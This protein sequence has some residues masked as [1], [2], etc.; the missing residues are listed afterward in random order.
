VTDPTAHV[1]APAVANGN[2]AT[3]LPATAR[4]SRAVAT[5]PT[6]H[7]AVIGHTSHVVE[8][9]HTSHV[10]MIGLSRQVAATAHSPPDPASTDPLTRERCRSGS[11]RA[12]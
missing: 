2:R 11:I 4:T 9:G 1:A 7:V 3:A 12:G 6:S 10:A 5:G 8:I